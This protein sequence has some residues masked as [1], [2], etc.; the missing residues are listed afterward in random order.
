MEYVICFRCWETFEYDETKQ[1][2]PPKFCSE[3]GIIVDNL[4]HKHRM[5]RRRSL[6]DSSLWEH[7]KKDF[8]A[9]WHAIQHE[10]RRLK[11]FL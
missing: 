9:E 4:K 2:R 7:R 6:G 10:K 5:Q 11:L 1:G 3:C 8:G